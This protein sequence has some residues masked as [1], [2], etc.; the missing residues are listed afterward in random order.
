MAAVRFYASCQASAADL[1][2]NSF[3]YLFIFC[4][5]RGKRVVIVDRSTQR[6]YGG[7]DAMYLLELGNK[8]G[9]WGL[10]L[11]ASEHFH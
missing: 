5:R 4:C 10:L 7:D 9:P 3:T 6:Y 11:N 2:I 8:T 1:F